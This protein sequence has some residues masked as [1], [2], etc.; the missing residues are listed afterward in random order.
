MV[1]NDGRELLVQLRRRLLQ[2][3]NRLVDIEARFN[4]TAVVDKPITL[5]EFTKNEIE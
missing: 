4:S 3:K 5:R 1:V 2:I